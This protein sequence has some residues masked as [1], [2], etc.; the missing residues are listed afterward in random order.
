MEK[1]VEKLLKEASEAL[2]AAGSL[3]ELDEV[4]VRYLGKKG[5]VTALLKGAGIE[6]ELK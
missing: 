2:D 4:R 5:E 6:F 3:K 1:Q